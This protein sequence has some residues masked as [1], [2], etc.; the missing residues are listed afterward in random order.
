MHSS[1]L[2]LI[3]DYSVLHLTNF[4]YGLHLFNNIT[5]TAK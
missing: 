1:F 4:I 3:R 2:Q 5:E